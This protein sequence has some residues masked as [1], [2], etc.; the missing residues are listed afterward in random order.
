MG[1][2]DLLFDYN[3]MMADVIGD[4]GI[5][6]EELNSYMDKAKLAHYNFEKKKGYNMMEWTKLPYEQDSVAQ[7]IEAFAKNVRQNFDYF[8]VLGIGGSALGA[9]VIFDALCHYN[10]N[11]LSKDK[12]NA[13]IFFVEDNV[14]PDRMNALLDVV[15]IKKT[16]FNVVTK[17]GKTTETL[18]QFLIVYK[19]L[20][21]A[22]GEEEANK[23][24]V[25]TTDRKKGDLLQV[26]KQ[27]NIKCFYIP[28]GVGGRYSV[29]SPVGLLPASVLGVDIRDM[30]MGAR[31]MEERCKNFES[32]P[33][34]MKAVLEFI[35][36]NKGLKINVM[37]PY[38]QSL[39][40]FSSWYAQLMGESLGKRLSLDNEV[41]NVG[42]T[43][44]SALGVTDQ[45][46][47]QQLYIEGPNDKTITF[48]TVS[49]TKT[50]I[51]TPSN[52]LNI[53]ELDY[54]S[55]VNLGKLIY[56]ENTATRYAL[57]VNGRMN[58]T[59]IIPQVNAYYLG[60]LFTMCMY[61]IVYLGE[62]F[63][64][65]AFDQP[66]VEDGKIATFAMLNK[67][68]YEDRLECIEMFTVLTKY[69]V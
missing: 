43:P 3:N 37:M 1:K 18:A 21:R 66:G 33:A 22:L 46:S 30:L 17:S 13:P 27:K 29:L 10:H 36:Y 60:Q 20:K 40:S 16:M 65:N 14:D 68:G 64:I 2:N 32:N 58:N 59:I 25:F 55:N 56:V 7:E 26:A 15:D 4:N 57:S 41:V 44:V 48:I 11:L 8:V 5:T 63:N 28:E 23:H 31:D 53:K 49:N 54:I 12:R 67:S 39:K 35:S 50:D 42:I 47:Q 61:E 38:S 69:I 9:S 51:I 19:L 62:M 24:I 34:V 45:H 6:N 52:S